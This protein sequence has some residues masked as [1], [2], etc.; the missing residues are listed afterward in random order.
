MCWWQRYEDQTEV[1]GSVV[2]VTDKNDALVPALIKIAEDIPRR[3]ADPQSNGDVEYELK[4][5]VE[6][7]QVPSTIVTAAAPPCEPACAGTT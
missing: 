5:K 1:W 2:V 7:V 6:A 3:E 4:A